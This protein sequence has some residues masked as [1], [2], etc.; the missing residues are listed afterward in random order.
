MTTRCLVLIGVLF[1]AAPLASAG[2]D[3]ASL[4]AAWEAVVKADSSTEVFDK[5]ADRAY[6]FKTKLFPFDG[7]L[8][9]LN[10]LVQDYG[11]EE[12]SMPGFA[13]GS[14]EVELVGFAQ[15]QMT[16]Y[17]RSYGYWYQLHTLYFDHGAGRWLSG[18][19]YRSALMAKYPASTRGSFA[20]W[21][22]GNYFLVIMVLLALFLWW[23]ARK[24]GRQVKTAM[25]RQDEAMEITRRSIALSEKAVQQNDETIRLLQEILQELK[26]KS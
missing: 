7:E 1:L 2:P 15:E 23:L 5:T 14:V 24:S 11:G 18:K 17:A 25:S 9:V 6:H 10:T 21:L 8:R 3:E 20:G 16:R 26:N 12:E 13:L 4:L 22:A 19:E